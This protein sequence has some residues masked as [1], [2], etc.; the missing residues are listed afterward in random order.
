VIGEKFRPKAGR[1]LSECIY[2]HMTELIE[3]E[4]KSLY[5]AKDITS[6][7]YFMQYNL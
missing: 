7:N 2:K 6:D 5:S 4:D 1:I 3:N